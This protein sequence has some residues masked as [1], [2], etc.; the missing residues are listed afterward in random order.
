MIVGAALRFALLG[1]VPPGLNQDE[2]V[3]GYDAYALALTGRDHLGHP[4]PTPLLESF[5]DWTSPLLTWLT[6][7]AVAAFGLHPIVLRAVS[8]AIGILAIPAT[9]LL[10]AE[11]FRRPAV[12][13]LAAWLVA[14]SP[15]HLHLSRWAIPPAT[16]PTTIALALALHVRTARTGRGR[17]ALAAAAAAGLAVLSYPTQRVY[18]PLVGLAGLLVYRP[19]LRRLPLRVV[20]PAA[21]LFLV[22]AGPTFLVQVAEPATRARAEQV[23]LF[24]RSGVA[25][26]R[27]AEQYLAYFSPEFLFV[28]ADGEPMHLPTEGGLEPWAALPLLLLGLG[29]LARAALPG[30]TDPARRPARLLLAA[31]ALYPFPGCLT[32]PAPHTLRAAHLIPLLAALAAVGAVVLARWARRTAASARSS[33]SRGL[34]VAL[35]GGLAAL[36]GSE[37]AVRDRAYFVENP[38]KLVRGF[39]VGA[40]EAVEYA[41]AHEAAYREVWVTGIRRAYVYVLF[42]AAWPPDD[43]RRNLR[44]ERAPPAPNRVRALGNYRFEDPPDEVIRALPVLY[45]VRAPDGEVAYEVRGGSSGDLGPIMVVLKP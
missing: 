32:V 14:L 4:F 20:G 35:A 38:T 19:R 33:V 3:S 42:Y 30:S 16:V 9:Y 23:S 15:W 34:P 10:G 36:L 18:L 43:A 21:A 1:S 41:L 29:R 37:L 44:V 28:R 7:P 45:A 22:L 5:G 40:G 31:L 24:Q 39:Q 27:L 2:A 26:G 25:P 13:L 12:G 11:L 17:D 8:A 6:V